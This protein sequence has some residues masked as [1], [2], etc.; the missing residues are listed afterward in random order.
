[1]GSFTRKY[2]LSVV[3]EQFRHHQKSYESL[4]SQ[5]E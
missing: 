5:N 2:F 1:M 3:Y 4:S